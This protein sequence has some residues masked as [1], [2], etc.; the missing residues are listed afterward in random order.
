MEDEI[1]EE[2]FEKSSE[3][4]KVS[5]LKKEFRSKLL[6]CKTHE[7]IEV[8]VENFFNSKV[9]ISMSGF[10]EEVF[11][12]HNNFGYLIKLKE[13]L[14]K[15]GFTLSANCYISL[16]YKDKKNYEYDDLINEIINKNYFT[17]KE[18]LKVTIKKSNDKTFEKVLSYIIEK[19]VIID[20]EILDELKCKYNKMEN[21]NLIEIINKMEIAC[22]IA[23]SFNNSKYEFV[24]DSEDKELLSFVV[25]FLEN[26]QS[27]YNFFNYFGEKVMIPKIIYKLVLKMR[28][29]NFASF[30][31]FEKLINKI[32]IYIKHPDFIGYLKTKNE[33]FLNYDSLI[34]AR[35]KEKIYETE[36]KISIS[37]DTDNYFYFSGKKE[38]FLNRVDSLNSFTKKDLYTEN[39]IENLYNHGIK[40]GIKEVRD[41]MDYS[42]KKLGKQIFI[43]AVIFEDDNKKHFR[44]VALSNFFIEQKK[45]IESNNSLN[46]YIIIDDLDE[47]ERYINN[48]TRS[49]LQ[50]CVVS[51]KENNFKGTDR[52]FSILCDSKFIENCVTKLSVKGKNK[53][54]E[55]V[56]IFKM[57]KQKSIYY[58][59]SNFPLIESL[60]EMME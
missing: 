43:I 21:K 16:L 60:E 42:F 8:L 24:F 41:I 11:R 23:E 1:L 3:D 12:Y 40:D 4:V 35:V 25:M 17:N 6:C 37:K 7:D 39:E 53:K 49:D 9:P 59:E 26:E 52:I 34:E 38:V 2:T 47:F 18:L 44:E 22:L 27:L 32:D 28:D 15:R 13:F 36:K 31:G 19:D 30:D 29:L 46:G 33:I 57:L 10:L 45:D 51:F 58:K 5:I 48:N 54:K 55:I 14:E 56:D 50:Y 20:F